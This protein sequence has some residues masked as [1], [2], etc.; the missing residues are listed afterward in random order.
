M[1]ETIVEVD[2]GDLHVLVAFFSE[3]HHSGDFDDHDDRAHLVEA[4]PNGSQDTES[5]ELHSLG[6]EFTHSNL[7]GTTWVN[8]S[9]PSL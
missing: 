8:I 5:I 2:V 4:R 6:S 9:L 1:R 3:H 7:R